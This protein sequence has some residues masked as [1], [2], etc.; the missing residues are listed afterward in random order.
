MW[1]SEKTMGVLLMGVVLGATLPVAG[2]EPY[3]MGLGDLSGGD[4]YSKANAV[5]GDGSVVVGASNSVSGSEAFCWTVSGGI[6]G[7]G[8][9]SGGSF[10]SEAHGVSFDGSVVVGRGSSATGG[11]AFYWTQAGGMVG[12]GDL[13][14]G[15]FDGT[16]Y[17]VSGD[18]WVVVGAS[19]SANCAAPYDSEAFY[20]T[21]V[22]GMVGLGDL[23]GGG[24][25]SRAYG[26]S[27]DGAVIV[28]TGTVPFWLDPG[29]DWGPDWGFRWTEET[30]MEALQPEDFL[31]GDFWTWANGVSADGSVIA[32]SWMIGAG[33]GA[34]GAVRWTDGTG[35]REFLRDYPDED[36]SGWATAVS[37]DGSVI[38][39]EDSEFG[40]FIWD[41]DGG[42]RNL[43]NL[44]VSE[45]GL[46]LNGL[47]LTE[48]TGISDDGLTVV[49]YGTNTDG[50][51]EGWV[52]HIP[53]PATLSLLAVGG[54]FV[55]RRRR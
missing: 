2:D 24:F 26:V 25:N 4:Y 6:S 1:I 18:G 17:D 22:G 9:L 10:G 21:E 12:L 54:L 20:W 32:G 53:E 34:S 31:E 14:G 45:L 51:T 43:Q 38:V 55:A 11:E 46:D 16:A 8:D 33:I 37:A 49:G 52:A 30:S 27:A 3:F 15:S 28:G 41:I 47:G 35:G 50:Y 19:N 39:G 44:L 5:S 40:V 36:S 29:D 23:P 13:P 42:M 7:L 48:V